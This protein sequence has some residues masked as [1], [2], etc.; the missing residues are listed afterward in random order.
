MSLLRVE[1]NREIYHR[2]CAHT[3]KE[4]FSTARSLIHIVID[5]CIQISKASVVIDQ[6]IVLPHILN[7][8]MEGA[9]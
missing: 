1:T 7:P 6:K 9:L 4:S 2:A 8:V 5:D 3:V